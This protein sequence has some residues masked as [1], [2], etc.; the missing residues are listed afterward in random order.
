VKRRMTPIAKTAVEEKDDSRAKT[1]GEEK[2][3]S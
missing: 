1:T 3:D 2:D